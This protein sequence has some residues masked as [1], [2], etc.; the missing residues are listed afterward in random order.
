MK[1]KLFLF[2][3]LFSSL[4]TACLSDDDDGEKWDAAKV[5]PETGTN[6]YGMPNRGT[7]TDERDGEVYHYTTI[8]D[9]VWMAENLR[10]ALPYP[11][12][13]CY[14]IEACYWHKRWESDEVGETSCFKDTASLAEIAERMQS[15]C[16]DN[17]CIAKEYCEKFGRYYSL[18]DR[19]QKTGHELLNRDVVDS[20]CPKGWHLPTK[21][22]W[23]ILVDNV[24]NDAL[25]LQS[26]ESYL[27]KDSKKNDGDVCGFSAVYAGYKSGANIENL[28]V[29]AYFWSSTAKGLYYVETMG[30]EGYIFFISDQ[31][32]I[33]LRCLRD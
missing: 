24:E 5:C 23:Q 3:L 10:F 31:G 28:F 7:F 17:D 32:A 27:F 4:L 1:K 25:R 15:S 20:V 16:T 30:L 22:E 19:D 2:A 13:F 33:S 14:G 26:G 6:S 29:D 11:Y 12:S 21:A 9:Q 18:K 8:G